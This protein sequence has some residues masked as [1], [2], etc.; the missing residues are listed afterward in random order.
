MDYNREKVD[1]MVLA[2][3]A[4]TNVQGQALRAGLEEPRLGRYGPATREG[5]HLRSEEPSEVGGH[6]RRGR[7]AGAEAVRAAL[8]RHR[9]RRV[10]EMP[11]SRPCGSIDRFP[12][13]ELPVPIS[14]RQ[15]A[16]VA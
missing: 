11:V 14:V 8:W 6:D 7:A 4:L 2:L 3:L 15:S 16:S 12:R 9:L 10:S 5:V 1:E 13:G